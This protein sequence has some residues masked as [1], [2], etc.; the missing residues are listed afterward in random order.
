MSEFWSYQFYGTLKP[1]RKFVSVNST[2]ESKQK[3]RVKWEF[4]GNLRLILRD[5][6][7]CY[8]S[9][10]EEKKKKKV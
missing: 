10:R 5:F 4:F 8:I 3:S 9:S 1:L 6:S 2:R 7:C